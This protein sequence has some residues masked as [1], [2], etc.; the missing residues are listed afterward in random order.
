M[1]KE[2]IDLCKEIL[3]VFDKAT[4]NLSGP[5]MV[6]LS[7]KFMSFG[8]MLKDAETEINKVL[9]PVN[10]QPIISKSIKRRERIQKEKPIENKE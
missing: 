7:M 6:Q 1:K 8:K 4:F 5:E 3:K 10:D 9:A 2:Q